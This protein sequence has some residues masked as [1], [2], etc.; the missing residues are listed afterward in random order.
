VSEGRTL[1]I[2][3]YVFDDMEVLDF[4]GPFEVFMTAS[5]LYMRA[6]G[7]EGDASQA[8]PPFAVF[9]IADTRRLIRARG[10]LSLQPH[11]V[12]ANRPPIDVFIVPGGIVNAEMA[13]PEIIAWIAETA[14]AATVTASVCTGAFLLAQAGLLR[15]KPATTHWEDIPDLAAQFPNVDVKAGVRWV[16]TGDIVTGA[17]ISAGIDM[18]LHLVARLAGESLAVK[19]ARQMDFDWQ[20][21]EEDRK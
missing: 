3:I 1:N 16:D 17:G 7:G 18:S 9:T 15:G 10:A 14:R 11:F 13:R 5:R 20:R 21:T 8:A 4:A 19:T 2:G 6:F 12:I